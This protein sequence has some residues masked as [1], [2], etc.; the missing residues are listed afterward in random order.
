MSS[1]WGRGKIGCNGYKQC[2]E[3]KGVVS[4]RYLFFVSLEALLLSLGIFWGF[5]G[6]NSD[7]F[8]S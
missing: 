7:G 8:M 1:E 6:F 3:T 5:Y 4:I 2:I